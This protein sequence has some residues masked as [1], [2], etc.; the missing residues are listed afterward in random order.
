LIHTWTL[1][2]VVLPPRSQSKW[3]AA[4]ERLGLT[5]LAFTERLEGLDHFL[6]SVEELMENWATI[7]GL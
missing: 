5:G 6:D 4:C 7:N 1:A 2:A 3:K